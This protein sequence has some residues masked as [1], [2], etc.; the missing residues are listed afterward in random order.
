LLLATQDSLVE[1]APDADIAV[2]SYVTRLDL[3]NV[4]IETIDGEKIQRKLDAIVEDEIRARRDAVY[5]AFLS[6]ARLDLEDE[7]FSTLVAGLPEGMRAAQ[8]SQD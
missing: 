6:H 2:R 4:P 8:A 3:G 7:Q 1:T 5:A